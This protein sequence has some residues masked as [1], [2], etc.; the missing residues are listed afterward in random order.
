MSRNA[1]KAPQCALSTRTS[2]PAILPKL[3]FSFSIS[4]PRA[5]LLQAAR[6]AQKPYSHRRAP[7]RR[8]HTPVS[9]SIIVTRQT[10]LEGPILRLFAPKEKV[11]ASG[12][13]ASAKVVQA[14]PRQ[15]E[16]LQQ[17]LLQILFF[18]QGDL[19]RFHLPPVGRKLPVH[20]A[21]NLE[22]RR[23]AGVARQRG[24]QLVVQNRQ[25]PL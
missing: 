20:F 5:L 13:R 15:P 16:F 12:K 19:F 9:Q 8:R 10:Y 7:G 24:V 21:P 2:P 23:F 18:N 1:G 11:M 25:A 6:R 22:H 14:Q 4:L 3:L 17:P